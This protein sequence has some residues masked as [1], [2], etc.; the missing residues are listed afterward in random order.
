MV[1]REGPRT[2]WSGIFA[3][4]FVF[5]AIEITFGVLGMAIFASAAN[6]G[7]AR[8]VWGESTGIA[9]WVIVETIIAFYFAGRAAGHLSGAVR[10][11]TGLY[12]GLVTFGMS[13]FAAVLIAGIA[14]GT[15]TGGTTGIANAS[16]NSV[17]SVAITGGWTLWLAMLLGGIAACIGGAHA[18]PQNLQPHEELRPNI[19]TAA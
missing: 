17:L 4:T 2:S 13:L 19:R 7:T 11:L 10:R 8:P 12:Q 15:T 9:A 14:L 16:P 18:V 1:P 6:L 3:G 5:L